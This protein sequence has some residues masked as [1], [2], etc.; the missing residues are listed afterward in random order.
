MAGGSCMAFMLIN[1]QSFRNSA[2]SFWTWLIDEALEVCASSPAI[3][4]LAPSGDTLSRKDLF[5]EESLAGYLEEQLTGRANECLEDILAELVLLGPP[6]PVAIRILAG[7][8]VLVE[9]D[10][11]IDIVDASILNYLLAWLL[12]WAGV[13]ESEWNAT[14]ATGTIHAL[15]PIRKRSYQIE[16]TLARNHLSEELYQRT[17]VLTPRLQHDGT[18]TARQ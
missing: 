16:Y 11:P 5:P 13:P 18:E 12:E 9:G 8:E 4:L 17:L 1:N 6:G 14:S 15:D 2:T 3:E 10:L 7:S